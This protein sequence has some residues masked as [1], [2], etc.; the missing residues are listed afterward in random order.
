[1]TM[2]SNG[3]GSTFALTLD[4][5][6]GAP[7]QLPADGLVVVRDDD[8]RRVLGCAHGLHVTGNRITGLV[9]LHPFNADAT[10]LR[11]GAGLRPRRLAATLAPGA[12]GVR[13][14]LALRPV[15]SLV[16]NSGA[17][18]LLAETG[19][20]RFD[21]HR[22]AAA[23]RLATQPPATDAAPEPRTRYS[24]H[25]HGILVQPAPARYVNVPGQRR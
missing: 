25:R 20:R 4:A 21:D 2:T 12:R 19:A 23:A 11:D 7:I 22:A 14:V 15:D 24:R 5:E 9:D 3:T 17:L 13:H 18:T 8:N 16:P 6:P 1:M 10:P